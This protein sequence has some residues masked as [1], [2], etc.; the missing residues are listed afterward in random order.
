V[1]RQV[2]DHL[3]RRLKAIARAPTGAR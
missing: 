2:P 3:Y 1:L